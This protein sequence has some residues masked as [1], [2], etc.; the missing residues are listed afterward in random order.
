MNSQY[1]LY[2]GDYALQIDP[3]T[4]EE[5]QNILNHPMYPK[6]RNWRIYDGINEEWV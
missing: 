1:T 6:D 2:Q 4:Y 3:L 5:A